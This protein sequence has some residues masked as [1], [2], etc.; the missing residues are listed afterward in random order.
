MVE[1]LLFQSP[2]LLS[3]FLFVSIAP[4]PPPIPPTKP[5]PT[6]SQSPNRLGGQVVSRPPGSVRGLV[7]PVSGYRDW[8]RQQVGSSTCISVWQHEQLSRQVRPR[9]TPVCCWHVRQP[10]NINK[11]S[12]RSSSLPPLGTS[13]T[14]GSGYAWQR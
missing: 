11:P 5:L 13:H 2:C 14:Q 1:E 3:V 7:G 4:P 10:T 12:L 6:P 8:V 9:G